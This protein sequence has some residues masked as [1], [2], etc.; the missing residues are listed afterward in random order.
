MDGGCR[1]SPNLP[2]RGWLRENVRAYDVVHVHALF[3]F[4]SIVAARAARRHR[5][6]YI[7]RPL[8]VLSRWGRENRRRWLKALSFR[9]LEL[10]LLKHASAVHYTSGMEMRDAARFGLKNRQA[11]IPIG[12]DLA[13][14]QQMPSASVFAQKFPETAA[15]RNVL[16]LSRVDVKKGL[17]LLIDAFAR[18]VP[19][20]PNLRLVVCGEGDPDLLAVLK[21]QAQ[22]LGV[23]ERITWAGQVS[24]EMR[25]AAFAA[26][27]MFVLPSHA[28]NFG[29]AL[30]EAMSA[31]LPCISTDQVALATDAALVSAVKI[32]E[33]DPA[34][35]AQAM[36]ELLASERLRRDLSLAAQN[37]ARDH[38]SV[39]SMGR[40]LHE[41]YQ[42]VIQPSD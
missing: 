30:L 21:Q 12:I 41:L 7:V 11:I 36:E 20:H 18:V 32:A 8:G 19:Q 4:S 38:Y 39:D 29:I 26:A 40:G 31:G 25:L 9:M 2:L 28:E 27:E 22:V 14:L 33:R 6:P 24:G 35:L 15:T 42:N 3:S 34:L 37:L 16:F 17:D 23:K 1:I 10:P 5:V 13:P